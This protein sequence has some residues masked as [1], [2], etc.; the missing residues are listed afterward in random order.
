M[1]LHTFR[2]I[3]AS[4]PYPSIVLTV[5]SPLKYLAYSRDT[6]RPYPYPAYKKQ[7]AILTYDDRNGLNDAVDI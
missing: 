5:R 4:V 3:I 2:V 6:G 1:L 7:Q